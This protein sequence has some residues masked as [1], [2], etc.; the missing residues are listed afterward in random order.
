[1]TRVLFVDD[2]PKVLDGLRQLMRS[3]RRDWTMEFCDSPER[4]LTLMA[5]T[6][7]DAIV[8]D[9]RMPRMDGAELLTRVRDAYPDTV[10]IL[11]SGQS[12][13]ERI[14]QAVGAAHQYLPKPCNPEVL[15]KIIS[16][17]CVLGRRMNN[18][19][20]KQLVTKIGSLPS[21]PNIYFD[22]VEELRS[23]NASVDRVGTLISQDISMMA[24][25]LQLVNSSFFG[26]PVHVNDARHA[27]ALLGLNALK[28]LVLT[29]CVFR[30]LEESR[31]SPTFLES[32]LAHSL[33]TAG[34]A[35]QLASAE[36]LCRETI[37]NTFIA[38]VLHDVGKVVLADNF[39][40]EY[41][42][43]CHQ[44]KAQQ[45][46]ILKLEIE[47]YGT[48]HADVGG[49]LLSLWG[50]PQELIEAVAFHHDPSNSA[51]ERFS[52]LTAVHVA[53]ALAASHGESE[54]TELPE[55]DLEYL[56]A[57]A[58]SD[59]FDDW[60]RL[61]ATDPVADVTTAPATDTAAE[62]V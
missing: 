22:L 47:Q 18:P 26:L 57:I 9:M 45:T 13:Q 2:E 34:L 12:E 33:T 40:R 8:S 60:H 3:Y 58:V 51:D 61:V 16:H 41:T 15:R 17:A 36:G 59:R 48:S 49:Y 23:E 32:V 10:R 54:F 38:G 46:S 28:P 14:L 62:T 53:N 31:V 43:L 27:A 37:D 19:Q 21:L 42:L 7:Y 30:Q 39:G 56:A 29:A 25:V 35:K 44:A 11:L 20:L 50:L 5:E 52:P 55:V 24:K 6:K 1:M 4:A